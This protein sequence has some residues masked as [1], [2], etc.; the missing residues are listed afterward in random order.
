MI[1]KNCLTCNKSFKTYPSVLEK[2]NGRFC[3]KKCARSGEFAS[4][5]IGGKRINHNGYVMIRM[6]N[7][8]NQVNGYVFEHRLIMES[9]I[10]RYLSKMEVVHHVDHNRQNNKIENLI[11]F[12]N[13]GEHNLQHRKEGRRMPYEGKRMPLEIRNKMKE[14]WISRKYKSKPMPEYLEVI[15]VR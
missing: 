12:A 8:P 13:N 6:P 9:Y 15:H 7:H 5:W 14:A 10:G 1:I 2:G 11:L 4:R 3:S